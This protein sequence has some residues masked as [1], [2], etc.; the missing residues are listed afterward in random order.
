MKCS[1]G[2]RDSAASFSVA[3]PSTPPPLPARLR[4]DN[5]EDL[6]LPPAT[7]ATSRKIED[8]RTGTENLTHEIGTVQCSQPRKRVRVSGQPSHALVVLLGTLIRQIV[9]MPAC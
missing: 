9:A 7:P 3:T 2:N 1:A 6:G 8:H 4:L 5:L